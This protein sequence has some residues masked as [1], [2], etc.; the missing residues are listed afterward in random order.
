MI[1]IHIIAVLVVVIVGMI[2]GM[3]FVQ[4][5]PQQ[6]K[7]Q[8]VNSLASKVISSI[9]A[10]GQIKSINGRVVT[11]NNLGDDLSI[12]IADN[13][14]ILSFITTKTSPTPVQQTTTF[15]KV[16]V[17][18]NVNIIMRLLSDGKLEGSSVII[19]PPPAK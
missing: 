19:L 7:I 3:T 15:D 9:A 13:A 12:T 11:L 14:Q 17:G 6:V 8:T 16:K 1:V 5:G 18:D 4:K 10:Y 2:L